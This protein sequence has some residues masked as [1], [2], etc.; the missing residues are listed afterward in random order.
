M[1]NKAGPKQ[2]S[3]RQTQQPR[4]ADN[5]D[6]GMSMIKKIGASVIQLLH[7]AGNPKVGKYRREQ[8]IPLYGSKKK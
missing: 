5:L 2:Y 6:E 8:G 4:K 7:E 3:K 1:A